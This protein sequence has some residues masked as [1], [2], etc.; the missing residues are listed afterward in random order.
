MRLLSQAAIVSLFAFLWCDSAFS[1]FSSE[2]QTSPS[3]SGGFSVLEAL[4]LSDPAEISLGFLS[5]TMLRTSFE[6]SAFQTMRFGADVIF[7]PGFTQYDDTGA[8]SEIFPVASVISM[9]IPFFSRE[10]FDFSARA[11]LGFE[12]VGSYYREALWMAS[13]KAVF[14]ADE[15]FSVGLEAS[16]SDLLSFHIDS[17]LRY[18][19]SDELSLMAG[20]MQKANQSYV[21]AASEL[22]MKSGFSLG[23][24][25]LYN[26]QRSG[27]EVDFFSR[28]AL[29][30]GLFESIA[31]ES[32]VSGGGFVDVVIL[33]EFAGGEK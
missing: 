5:S 29:E 4:D 21:K 33:F 12:S 31:L 19:I 14:A 8:Q 17:A 26:L 27:F 2:L 13:L 32:A 6:M 28:L 1:L 3:A 23:F 22:K 9:E 18:R 15:K 7:I 20:F 24:S 30:S 11:Y 25:G 10:V 16:Y